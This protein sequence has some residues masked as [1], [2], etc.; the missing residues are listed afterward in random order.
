MTDD[1]NAFADVIETDSAS[2]ISNDNITLFPTKAAHDTNSYQ[3]S[4]QLSIT[5]R[6]N[7]TETITNIPS[8]Q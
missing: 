1:F 2:T 8:A 6:D 5:P 3:L 7:L 4:N